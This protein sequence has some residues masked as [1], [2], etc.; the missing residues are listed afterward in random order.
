MMYAAHYDLA[1][2]ASLY[3]DW[4]FFSFAILQV[5][6]ISIEVHVKLCWYLIAEIRYWEIEVEMYNQLQR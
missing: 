5:S 2:K 3:F 6:C 4:V 1:I